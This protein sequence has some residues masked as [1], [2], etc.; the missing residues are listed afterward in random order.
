MTSVIFFPCCGI[1]K[2]KFFRALSSELEFLRCRDV[3]FTKCY[4][5]A[6]NFR[7]LKI[8]LGEFSFEY[9]DEQEQIVNQ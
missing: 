7:L 2:I 8:L 6:K 1:V 4:Y 3:E 5:H 9:F